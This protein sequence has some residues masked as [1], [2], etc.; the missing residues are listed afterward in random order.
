VV[1]GF[2]YG[3]AR[4]TV[5]GARWISGRTISSPTVRNGLGDRFAADSFQVDLNVR[6]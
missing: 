1:L 4:D 5:L 3:L 2:S 6:Y